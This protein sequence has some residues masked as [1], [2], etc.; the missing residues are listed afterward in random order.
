MLV[1][2][3][4]HLERGDYSFS[5]LDRMVAGGR[6]RGIE[7]FGITEH[8]HHFRQF[9][10]CYTSVIRDKTWVGSVQDEWLSG[11][12]MFAYELEEWVE[13]VARAK[14]AG[15]PI[16]LGIEVCYFPGQEE[17]IRKALAPY[18]WDYITEIGRAHV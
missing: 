17:Q 7:E 13:F 6:A 1:D 2:Y 11:P 4:M 9:K 12:K 14:A 16:K 18:P 8:T 15:Y 3:H 10:P 5:Y